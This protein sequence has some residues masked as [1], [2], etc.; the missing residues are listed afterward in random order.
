MLFPLI[1][2]SNYSKNGGLVSTSGI[3]MSFNVLD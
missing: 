1:G 3:I 2:R